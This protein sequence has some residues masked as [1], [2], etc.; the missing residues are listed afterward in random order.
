MFFKVTLLFCFLFIV[1]G[2]CAEKTAIPTIFYSRQSPFGL[3]EV[4][5]TSEP[6]VLKICEDRVYDVIH[7][8][9]K[10]GDPTYLGLLYAPLVTTS[11][12][13][14]EKLNKVLLLGLG[15]GDFLSYFVNY[16]PTAQVDAVEINPVMID[17][18]KKFREV[19][20]KTVANYHC[21]D[22]FKYVNEIKSSYD[23]IFCDMY[24]GKPL[25]SNNYKDL[26]KKFK[27][28]L[29]EGGVF[30]FNA[31]VPFVPRTVVEDLFKNFE[32]ITA[33]V[34]NDGANIIFI[35]YK[36]PA[37]NKTDIENVAANI[38]AKYNFRYA[39]PDLLSK[40]SFISSEQNE[41]WITKFPD[42]S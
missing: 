22:G 17:I 37:K 2:H 16:F 15:A 24:F 19:D 35:C 30:V 29:N 11:F 6:G 1:A 8:T 25:I 7:S 23:L 21:K 3:I 39:M 10:Q 13:F 36:G 5:S 12:C 33:A 32:N 42:L 9:F 18:V 40:F 31:Y 4:V 34:T 26:F 28:L 27:N 20:M 41:T 14:A 38:Q